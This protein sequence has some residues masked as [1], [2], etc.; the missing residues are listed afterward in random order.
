MNAVVQPEDEGRAAAMANRA[1]LQS[2]EAWSHTFIQV[3]PRSPP[4]VV[5]VTH[6]RY[7]CEWCGGEVSGS[8]HYWYVAG[9]SA[10]KR[11]LAHRVGAAV[12]RETGYVVPMFPEG[13]GPEGGA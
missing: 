10:G 12:R 11:R 6:A 2:C 5:P 3:V 7:R 1:K 9:V 13:D 4:G 8:A